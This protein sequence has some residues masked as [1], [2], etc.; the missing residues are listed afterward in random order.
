MSNNIKLDLKFNINQ[1]NNS[2]ESNK[3]SIKL[4]PIKILKL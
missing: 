1:L 3:V 4:S 2:Y